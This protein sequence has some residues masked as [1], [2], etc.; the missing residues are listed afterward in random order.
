MNSQAPYRVL[1]I[2]AR[3]NLGGPAIQISGLYKGMN[4]EL[5]STSL[6]C[7]FCE[8]NEID[9]LYETHADIPAIRVEGLG[10]S[11]NF[12]RDLKSFLFIV[13]TIRKLKPDIVHT[14]T[15]KAG[16]LGR[17][18]SLVS[19]HR[20]IRIHTF[21]GHLLNGYFGKRKTWLV[22]QLEKFLSRFTH[23]TIAV[24]EHVREDLLRAKIGDLDH[25]TVVPPGVESPQEVSREIARQSLN[26]N[27]QKLV[28]SFIGRIEK[29][30]RPDRFLEAV[31]LF[32]CEYPD[33]EFLVAGEGTL[34]EWMKLEVES[35]NLP[36][37]FLGWRSDVENVICASDFVVLT[38]DNE[39]MPMALIQ[40]SFLGVPA[41]ATNVGSVTQVIKDGLTG[42]I[43]DTEVQ[44][45]SRKML[46][47]AR[48]SK[49]RRTLGENARTYAHEHFHV[50]RLVRDHENLYLKVLKRQSTF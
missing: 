8:E 39:G 50:S 5:F 14:H 18:A 26:L 43:S 23:E 38:S 1:R 6:L 10:R 47:L 25:F 28:I 15:A 7:G 27:L 20:S 2:I 29:V 31:K 12:F 24:G 22:V 42:L 36:V 17:I 21:H 13:K 41:V 35:D 9:Y 30:K 34:L 49:L 32:T 48:D 3:M 40:S 11:V 19:L 4:Q 44:S 37:K 16:V 46:K 33:V 45:I